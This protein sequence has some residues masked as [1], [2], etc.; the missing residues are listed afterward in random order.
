MV[1][2]D[3]ADRQILPREFP[4]VLPARFFLRIVANF[5]QRACAFPQHRHH[6]HRRQ[7]QLHQDCLRGRLARGQSGLY[8]RDFEVLLRRGGGEG[9][10]GETGEAG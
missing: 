2:G 6:S 9:V 4:P 3:R 7:G 8:G 1:E 5:G 10:A